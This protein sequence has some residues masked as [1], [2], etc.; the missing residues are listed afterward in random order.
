MRKQGHKHINFHRKKL[1][2]PYCKMEI[3]HIECKTQEDVDEFKENF[4]N[5]EYK[6]EV[7]ESFAYVRSTRLR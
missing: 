6:D 5:G 1:Y 3:N 4:L 2:C 7:E